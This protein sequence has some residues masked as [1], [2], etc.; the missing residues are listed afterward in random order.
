MGAFG[1][2]TLLPYNLLFTLRLEPN[3]YPFGVLMQMNMEL[4]AR[5][6]VHV[7]KPVFTNMRAAAC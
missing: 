2:V 4:H 5:R 1:V 3:G 6:C 7:G